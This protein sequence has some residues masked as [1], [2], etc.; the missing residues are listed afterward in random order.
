MS[1]LPNLRHQ[2][3]A[4][5]IAL[6][7]LT[8][9]PALAADNQL[10]PAEKAAG[11]QLLFDGETLANWKN[12]D[13]K[14]IAEGVIQDGTINTHGVGGYIL[15]YDQEFNDFELSCDVKMSQGECNSGVFVRIGDLADPVFTGIEVQVYSPPGTSLHDFG[16]I[17]DLVPPAMIATR[18]PGE[19]NNLLVRC[20]GPLISSFVN[21]QLVAEM[22]C[23]EF[24]QPGLRPDGTAHKFGRAIKDF[25]R[26]G[27]VGF[28]DHGNDVWFKN[29]KLR[30]LGDDGE[31]KS[32]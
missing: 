11:W 2:S 24:D 23:D 31:D 4:F 15:V 14:P 27:Y 13:G 30:E 3:A 17:Y 12:N 16:A 28:Q 6:L 19:W 32:N 25:A 20:E 10:S 29:I 9:S 21:G 5:A 1:L 8:N 22:N 18:E 7:V 26:S